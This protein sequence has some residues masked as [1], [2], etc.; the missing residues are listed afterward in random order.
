MNQK[1][2]NLDIA[3]PKND[4]E[5]IFMETLYQRILGWLKLGIDEDDIFDTESDDK[6]MAIDICDKSLHIILN[7]LRIDYDGKSV[8]VGFDETGQIVELDANNDKTDHLRGSHI[9][10]KE[11]AYFAADWIEKE[12]CRKIERHEWSKLFYRH[13]KWIYPDTGEIICW[14]DSKNKKRNNLGN[15]SKI[16]KVRDFKKAWQQL[17]LYSPGTHWH[18][19]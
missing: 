19:C 10:P 1:S 16:V 2:L 14:S 6:L 9:S 5:R 13:I 12:L 11:F 15:P 17:T 18:F 8:I 7:T 4:T 3:E